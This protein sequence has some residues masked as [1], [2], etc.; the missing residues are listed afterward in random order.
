MNKKIKKTESMSVET[1]DTDKELLYTEQDEL[2]VF[3]DLYLD[4]LRHTGIKSYERF[5]RQY[6]KLISY[7]RNIL[8]LPQNGGYI[9]DMYFVVCQERIENE[10]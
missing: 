5:M 7:V 6:N 3:V 4:L 2:C 1:Q 9:L 10:H 8:K